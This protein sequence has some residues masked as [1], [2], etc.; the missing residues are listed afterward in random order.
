M[1]QGPFS[2]PVFEG[3]FAQYNP[4]YN[5]GYNPPFPT[6]PFPTRAAPGGVIQARFGW[7]NPDSGLVSNMPVYGTET[8]GIVLPQPPGHNWSRVYFDATA[9]AVRVREGLPVTVFT[10]GPF[11][12]RF[13]A[14]AVAGN[15]VYADVVDG[16]AVSGQTGGAVST[17]WFVSTNTAPGGL[18]IVSTSAK[19]GA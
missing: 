6:V 19:F 14:G 1:I 15:R 4:V 9:C 12:L 11:Y 7:A 8:L 3:A 5:P 16:H 17:P 13:A 10:G 18:A 2:I